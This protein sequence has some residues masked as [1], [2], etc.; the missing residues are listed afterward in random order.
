MRAEALEIY[1]WKPPQADG[2]LSYHRCSP[3]VTG[4]SLLEKTNLNLV[5]FLQSW[6]MNKIR[7]VGIH[8]CTWTKSLLKVW[9]AQVFDGRVR[10]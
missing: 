7:R 5:Q 8:P 3:A 4:W 1:E 2:S 9:R 6:I 10:G